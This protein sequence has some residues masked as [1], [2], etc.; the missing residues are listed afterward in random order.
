MQG[1][2]TATTIINKAETYCADNDLRLTD[3]RRHVLDIMAHAN[4][5][6][7][8]YDIL[9][10][11]GDYLDNPKPPTAY[12]A[13][14]FW[15]EHGFIHRI[16]SLNAYTLCEAGHRHSGSQFLICDTCKTV[17]E[18]HLCHLPKTLQDKADE[19]DFTIRHW[20]VEIHGQCA[21]CSQTV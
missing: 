9:S 6:I 17:T 3:P 19:Q 15:V 1:M 13:I 16:E 11:L 21:A 2:N 5:P 14:D 20:S 18:A 12:R 10:K 7:G 8:A 4:K